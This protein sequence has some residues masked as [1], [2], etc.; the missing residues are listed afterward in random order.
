MLTLKILSDRVLNELTRSTIG[1][2]VG[3]LS[4]AR[5]AAVHTRDRQIS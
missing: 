4:E 3:R 5:T 2:Q 1:R